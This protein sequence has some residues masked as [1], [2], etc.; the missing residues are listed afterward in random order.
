MEQG[1]FDVAENELLVFKEASRFEGMDL[2]RIREVIL[3]DIEEVGEKTKGDIKFAMGIWQVIEDL[4]ESLKANLSESVEQRLRVFGLVKKLK[5]QSKLIIETKN[6]LKK[7]DGEKPLE[8]DEGDYD[9]L[10]HLKYDSLR[11]DRY[12]CIAKKLVNRERKPV[13]MLLNRWGD[14]TSKCILGTE[15]FLVIK[16]FD[17]KLIKL[18]RGFQ[19]YK[20]L[21]V[22]TIRT[23]V[24]GKRV[25]IGDMVWRI[26][27][28]LLPEMGIKSLSSSGA[29]QGLW[30][31]LTEDMN[32]EAGG[33]SFE[34]AVK[35][36]NECVEKEERIVEAKAMEGL[37]VLFE[38]F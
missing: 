19:K 28:S 32:N 3:G 11:I 15:P 21:S 33:F 2:K 1:E 5:V 6:V 17:D 27:I 16:D 36:L 20:R 13:S 18:Q 26:K 31:L 14:R 34:E 8:M 7:E 4:P 10:F 22:I 35:K 9:R 30:E 25:Y 12:H 38:G 23:R 24:V 37:G 29:E